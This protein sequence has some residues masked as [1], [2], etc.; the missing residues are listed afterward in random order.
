VRISLSGRVGSLRFFR[1]DPDGD[2]RGP[3]ELIDLA[4]TLPNPL[5][6]RADLSIVVT[7]ARTSTDRGTVAIRAIT[8]SGLRSIVAPK[9]N[10][11]REGIHLDG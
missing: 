2:G 4:G 7:R 9:A 8:G 10:L 11:N 5:R 6:P 1:T 3:I